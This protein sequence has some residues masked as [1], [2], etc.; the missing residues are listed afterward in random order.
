[1]WWTVTRP[2]GVTLA[3]QMSDPIDLP[4]AAPP[5]AG[6]AQRILDAAIRSAEEIGLR[7][8][9][10]EDI[11]HAAGLARVTL[12]THFRTK[13]AILRAALIGELQRVLGELDET[14]ARPGTP[15]ERLVRTVAH[16]YRSL[17]DHRLL[18]RMLRTESEALLPYITGDSLVLEIAR[19]WAAEKIREVQTGPHRIDPDHGGELLMRLIH[20]LVLS[21][22]SSYDLDRPG[23]VERLA[24]DWVVPALRGP[25][26]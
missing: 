17:R 23:E 16:A 6:T 5:A 9:T 8:V 3:G 14:L 2:P 4:G 18:Q 19:A 7:R 10:M 11:A 1:M 24:R 20:S 26:D 15:E 12:Y 25:G 21:S 13:D 22:A